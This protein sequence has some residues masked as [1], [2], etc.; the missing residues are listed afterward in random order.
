MS[1]SR[2]HHSIT[3]PMNRRALSSAQNKKNGAA[4]LAANKK[5]AGLTPVSHGLSTTRT[6]LNANHRIQ[7]VPAEKTLASMDNSAS[8]VTGNSF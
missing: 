8:A 7:N 4:S 6:E 3:N 5:F 2:I 1:A